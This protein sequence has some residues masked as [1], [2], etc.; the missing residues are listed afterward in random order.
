MTD[1]S[2][3]GPAAQRPERI[4][5]R[6]PFVAFLFLAIAIGGLG[7]AILGFIG[8]QEANQTNAWPTTQGQVLGHEIETVERTLSDG[9][10]TELYIAKV[11]YRYEVDGAFHIS[12]K[13]ALR[14]QERTI[15]GVA[16]TEMEDFGLG[17]K[18][19]VFYNKDKPELAVLKSLDVVGAYQAISAGL[20][21]GLVCL[22]MFF[23]SLRRKGDV[24]KS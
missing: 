7:Y 8:L 17:K 16:E 6:S 15:K 20:C 24:A 1:I 12:D 2:S 10:K 22:F 11:R 23:T 19:T 9:T 21:I 13:I 4:R 3:K 18:V 5:E 14:P